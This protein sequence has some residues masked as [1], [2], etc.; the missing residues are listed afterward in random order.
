[1]SGRNGRPAQIHAGSN[2]GNAPAACPVCQ[3]D[4]ERLTRREPPGVQ[5]DWPIVS[6][7]DLFCGFGGMTVGVLEAAADAKRRLTIPL[8][9]DENSVAAD[10]YLRNFPQSGIKPA[11]VESL[12]DGDLDAPLTSRERRLRKRIGHVSILVGGPPCQGHSDLNNKTRRNDPRNLLYARMARAARVLRPEVVII[13][14]VPQVAH[15]HG[16]VVEITREAL[17]ALEYRV[18][19]LTFD[20]RKVG[21]PQRRKRHLV[22]AVPASFP[23]PKVILDELASGCSMDH[24]TV[25]WAI[26]DLEDI[27]PLTAFDRASI[28]SEEN[29]KRID[30]LFDQDIYNLD[31]ADRPS[32]HRDNEHTYRSMYGRLWWNQPAQTITTGFGSMGQGRYVHP[33]RRRT[34]TPHEA[35]RIQT[36]PDYVQLGLDEQ[37]GAWAQ[38]IGNAVPPFL[39]RALAQRLIPH[40]TGLDGLDEKVE[41]AKPGGTVRRS[42]GKVPAAVH[43]RVAS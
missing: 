35:A 5:D 40:L 3:A 12:I 7:V 4:S 19:A 37:R 36:I 34:L 33:T 2:N 23:S 14:N 1:M 15:D 24:R 25:G 18:H 20:L 22:L 32:C 28:P 8:A 26:S 11:K 29:R 17:E 38:M 10:A 31:N 13:E 42:N 41:V 39:T 43:A 16:Q 6:A 21:V 30:K 27:E 9:M